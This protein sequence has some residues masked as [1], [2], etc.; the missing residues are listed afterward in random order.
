MAETP[1]QIQV[2]EMILQLS[3]ARKVIREQNKGLRHQARK[4][5]RL[6]A[7][8]EAAKKSSFY[9]R[10]VNA[11]RGEPTRYMIPDD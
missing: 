1:G 7:E 5:K 8:L 4:I 3:N 2:Y 6:R 10:F 9:S 11:G